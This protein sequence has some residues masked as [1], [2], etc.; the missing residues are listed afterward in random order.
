M[1]ARSNLNRIEV[2]ISKA[3]IDSN[4]SHGE[5]VLKN[6]ELKDMKAEIKNLVTCTAYQSF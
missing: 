1:L 4:I 5:F 3:S 6:N 2:L